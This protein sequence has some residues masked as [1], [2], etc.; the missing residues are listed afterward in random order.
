VSWL[1]ASRKVLDPEGTKWDVYV[2]R[3]AVGDPGT[4]YHEQD[5]I[6]TPFAH[7]PIGGGLFPALTEFVFLV[8]GGI[9]RLVLRL[10]F[11]LPAGLIR[12]RIGMTWRIEAISDWPREVVRVWTVQGKPGKLLLDEIARGLALGKVPEP[13]G[14]T[15]VGEKER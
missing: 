11:F 7:G 10:V 9:L 5:V 15:Y 3:I 12:S 13:V 14:A 1:R 2:T 6:G 4:Q 8:L